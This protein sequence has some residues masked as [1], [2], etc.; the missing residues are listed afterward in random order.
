MNRYGIF[1]PTNVDTYVH[2]YCTDNLQICYQRVTYVLNSIFVTVSCLWVHAYLEKVDK[3]CN[4]GILTSFIMSISLV[5]HLSYTIKWVEPGTQNYK[6]VI[7]MSRTMKHKCFLGHLARLST[8]FESLVLFWWRENGKRT[9]TY[10]MLWG[11]TVLLS[12]SDLTQLILLTQLPIYPCL[13]WKITHTGEQAMQ[14]YRNSDKINSRSKSYCLQ[15][16][17]HDCD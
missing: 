3:L 14:S 9:N 4:T 12:D 7:T 5:L 11:F 17:F 10:M 16:Y 13:C 8:R 2:R 6:I 1:T 15:H